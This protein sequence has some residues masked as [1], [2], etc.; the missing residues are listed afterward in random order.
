MVRLALGSGDVDRDVGCGALPP[1]GLGSDG[2]PYCCPGASNPEE[3][4]P[5]VGVLLRGVLREEWGGGRGGWLRGGGGIGG[6]L[7]CRLEVALPAD[8]LE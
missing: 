8:E 2:K 7:L 3:S 1:P 5:F 6:R 4:G